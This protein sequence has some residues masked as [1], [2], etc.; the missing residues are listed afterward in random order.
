MYTDEEVVIAALLAT[1]QQRPVELA[2]IIAR[3]QDIDERSERITQLVERY[4]G[5]PTQH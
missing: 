5:K 4:N 2:R 1:G 3:A